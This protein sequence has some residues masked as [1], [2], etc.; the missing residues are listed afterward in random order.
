MNFEF[1]VKTISNTHGH[2]QHQAAKAVNVSLTLRNWLVGFYIVEFELNGEDRSTYGE[3]LFEEL[4]KRLKSINGVDRRALYRFKD[5]YLLYPQISIYIVDNQGTLSI[6]D[7]HS[8]QIV[9]ATT[10]QIE[11]LQ[12][13]GLITPQFI[14]RELQKWNC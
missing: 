8:Y 10:P 2:F 13:V 11:K 9:G 14:K 1:L 7:L 12:I 3:K 5:F 6:S 4:A